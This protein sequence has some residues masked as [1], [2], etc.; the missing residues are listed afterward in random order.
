MNVETILVP[1]DFSPDANQAVATATELARLFKARVVLMHAYHLAIPMASPVA[2]AYTLP[3]GFYE[4]LR[5]QATSQSRG[6]R[7]AASRGRCRGDWR[8]SFRAG[9]D[10]HRCTGRGA[11]G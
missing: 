11:S 1:T 6:S 4:E 10:G 8:R 9:V 7:E 5:A 3:D 2:G